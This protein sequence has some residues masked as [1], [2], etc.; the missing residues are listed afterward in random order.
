MGQIYR[1]LWFYRDVPT[2]L[3]LQN[4]TRQ[5]QTVIMSYEY[6]RRAGHPGRVSS[7][8]PFP[9][10][11]SFSLFTIH[12]RNSTRRAHSTSSDAS[13]RSGA[14]QSVFNRPPERGSAQGTSLDQRQRDSQSAFT[15]KRG[16][17]QRTGSRNSEDFPILACSG[18]GRREEQGK[19]EGTRRRVPLAPSDVDA[20]GVLGALHPRQQL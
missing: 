3:K 5:G 19:R 10:K 7:E 2:I 9:Q 17:H 4:F 18:V 14:V 6:R 11:Y 8:R 15:I 20:G 16:S 12:H 1:S 13:S